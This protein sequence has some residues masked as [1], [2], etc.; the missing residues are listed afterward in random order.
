MDQGRWIVMEGRSGMARF[1]GWCHLAPGQTT[2]DEVR[3]TDCTGMGEPRHEID[4]EAMVLGSVLFTFG[5]GG[6]WEA[7]PRERSA[8]ALAEGS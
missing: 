3:L 4:V 2:F 7:A 5:D 8:P 1:W 6:D